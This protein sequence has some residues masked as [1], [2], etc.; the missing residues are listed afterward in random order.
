[1]AEYNNKRTIKISI[2]ITLAAALIVFVLAMEMLKYAYTKNPEYAEWRLLPMKAKNLKRA[3]GQPVH[4]E[5][6]KQRQLTKN[7]VFILS[8][9]LALFSPLSVFPISFIILRRRNKT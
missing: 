9:A 7:E 5:P 3:D 6:D 1:M 8:G 4:P 2:V